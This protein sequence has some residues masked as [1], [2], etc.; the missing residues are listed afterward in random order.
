M[1]IKRKPS[2][3]MKEVST[4]VKGKFDTPTPHNHYIKFF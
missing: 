3:K 2:K 1:G 4:N